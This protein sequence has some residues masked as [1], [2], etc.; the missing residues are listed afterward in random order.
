MLRTYPALFHLED[1]GFWVE[2]PD[3]P[4]GTFGDDLEEAMLNSHDF[5]EGVLASYIDEEMEL[6]IA[7]NI[8]DL[9]IDDGFATLIQVDPTPFIKYNKTV[10]KNITIPEWL[11][12]RAD[13]A[14]I[15]YSETLTKVLEEVLV[16]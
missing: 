14:N 3:F 9:E 11:L 13:K 10:R 12:K 15:N 1:K 5:L 7:S 8:T 2:F 16:K 6:P 4:G